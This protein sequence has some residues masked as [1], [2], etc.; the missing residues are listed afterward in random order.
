MTR[1][2]VTGG[3]GYIGSHVVSQLIRNGVEVAVIDDLST[4]RIDRLKNFDIDFYQGSVGDKQLLLRALKGTDVVLHLAACK[5]VGESMTN[6]LKYWRSNLEVTL[7]LLECCELSDVNKIIFS[8]TA[9]VYEP[10][11]DRNI[12][13]VDRLKPLSVYGET[14]LAGERLFANWGFL[15]NRNFIILRYFNVAGSGSK[16]M[17]DDSKDNLI[18]KIISQVSNNQVTQIYGINYDTQD[19]TCIRD[20]LHV[21]DV[22]RAH[23]L[24]LERIQADPIQITLNVGSGKGYSVKE[25]INSIAQKMGKTIPSIDAGRR[26]GDG[27]RLVADTNRIS[28]FLGWHTQHDLDEIVESSI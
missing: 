5:S 15:E 3:A 6:P 8:S 22:A 11:S 9:A 16:G 13:E 4:G 1:V 14:K 2:L 7:S 20:Y 21:N 12:S 19:G 23:F 26:L 17:Q 28:E 24:A 27:A 10:I 25:V 18:P